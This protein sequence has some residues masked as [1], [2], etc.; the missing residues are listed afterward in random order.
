MNEPTEARLQ[1]AGHWL[2][3]GH[4]ERT[5]DELQGL[6]GDAALDYRDK[7]G[8]LA[9]KFGA[10]VQH[11]NALGD[12]VLNVINRPVVAAAE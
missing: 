3:I 2:Q 10:A 8:T 4:P 1:M 9:S 5:L 6:W 12:A 11:V 7:P